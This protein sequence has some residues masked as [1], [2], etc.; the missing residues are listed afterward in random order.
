MNRK[1]PVRFGGGRLEKCLCSTS[2][3]LAA[4]PV[5]L[6][7]RLSIVVVGIGADLGLPSAYNGLIV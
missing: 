4:Y 6:R 2:N 7:T 3:S 5:H 1:V